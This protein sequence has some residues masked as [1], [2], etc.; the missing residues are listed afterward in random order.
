MDKVGIQGLR[1]FAYHGVHP[2][3]QK[4][5]CWFEVDVSMSLSKLNVINDS[6]AE[7]IDYVAISDVAHAC[8]KETRFLNE[9]VANDI[10]TQCLKKF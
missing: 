2:Q 10:A 5:G 7:T 8:M 1:F 9:T 3:E 4:L 6:L